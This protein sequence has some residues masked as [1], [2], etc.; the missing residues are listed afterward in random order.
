[1]SRPLALVDLDDTLFQTEAK[2]PEGEGPHLALAAR[3]GNGRHSYATRVQASLFAWLSET[4]DLVPVTAR[5][6]EAFSRVDL[7]FR[8]G[9]VL[10]NGAVILRPDGTPDPEWR[11]HV[12]A[13]LA[14]A[15]PTMNAILA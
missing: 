11:D 9:A 14:A 13:G 15:L 1:M 6:T 4:A 7:P 8:C 12:A 10:A 3:S 5:G 2:C